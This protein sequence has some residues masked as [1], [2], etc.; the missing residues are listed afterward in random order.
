MLSGGMID[1]QVN[2][3]TQE[4]TTQ[5]TGKLL[6]IG[7]EVEGS[8]QLACRPGAELHSGYVLRFDN[9]CQ[10]GFHLCGHSGCRGRQQA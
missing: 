7:V 5:Y 3:Q 2:T 1:C 10:D 9:P 4:P 8:L 6:L